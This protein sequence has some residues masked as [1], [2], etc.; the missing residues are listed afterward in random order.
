MDALQSMVTLTDFLIAGAGLYWLAQ[1]GFAAWLAYERGRL[2]VGWYVL[3][4]V[5][6]PLAVIAVGLSGRAVGDR[7]LAC[8]GC[9][10]AIAAT[11][12]IC[13]HCRSDF[14]AMEQERTL[15]ARA[16]AWRSYSREG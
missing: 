16:E 8:P 10:E 7:Y 4:L 2:V 12:L 9:G 6:G 5:F 14:A 3:G 1:A 13:P 11:A 15:R